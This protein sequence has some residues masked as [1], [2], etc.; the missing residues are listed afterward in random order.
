MAEIVNAVDMS[1]DT[2]LNLAARIGNK[3]II[4]QLLE[5]GA[6]PT[7]P[8]RGGLKPVDFGVGGDPELLE[9]QPSSQV[10]RLDKALVSKVEESRQ[11]LMSCMSSYVAL[12]SCSY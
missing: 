1:G 2:A 9:A 3:S 11:E 5:V 10:T 12:S 7:I 4:Q 6:N 8:N